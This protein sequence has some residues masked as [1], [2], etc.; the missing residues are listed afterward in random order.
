MLKGD[1]PMNIENVIRL[2]LVCLSYIVLIFGLASIMLKRV[3]W[4]KS[5][6]NKILLYFIAGNFYVMNIVFY[7]C[8]LDARLE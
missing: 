8:S 6:S 2:S 7:C 5:F 4:V 3:I 1:R